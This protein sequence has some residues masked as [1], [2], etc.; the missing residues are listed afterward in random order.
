M[1]NR[2]YKNMKNMT[3]ISQLAKMKK[4]TNGLSV[5]G[6]GFC[7]LATQCHP[8]SRRKEKASKTEKGLWLE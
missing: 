1:A 3:I 4:V 5:G 8:S 2:A 7:L 6:A